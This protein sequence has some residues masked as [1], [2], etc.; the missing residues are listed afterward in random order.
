MWKPDL[1][2]LWE[3]QRP[4]VVWYVLCI[5][6]PAAAA[7]VAAITHGVDAWLV[8]FLVLFLAWA[9]AA[10]GMATKSR[11]TKEAEIPVTVV[12]AHPVTPENIEPR[13]GE[14]LDSFSLGRRKLANETAHFELEVKSPT[15]V[16]IAVLRTKGH[17]H[18]ITLVC[19]IELGEEHKVLFDKLSLLE[20]TQFVR[21]LRLDAAKA[22]IA[23]SFDLSGGKITIEKRLPITNTFSEAYLIDGLSEVNFSALVV[24]E[25]AASLLE[26]AKQPASIPST[27]ASPHSPVS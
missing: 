2:K 7:R 26:E 21:R 22:R 16:P 27:A 17:P 5:I 12:A 3:E 6:V 13:I 15:G 4:N 20:K 25:T 23:Y 8:F 18:Y 14:W 9:V 11:Q 10:T 19:K 24:M 1:R